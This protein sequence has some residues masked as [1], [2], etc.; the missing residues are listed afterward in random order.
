MR[1][2]QAGRTVP[3]FRR[4][5]LP[6]GPVT[7]NLRSDPQ[8]EEIVGGK[9]VKSLM[10]RFF[11][12]LIGDVPARDVLGHECMSRREARRHAAFIAQRIG[13]ERPNFAKP[14]SG[15]AVRDD[16]GTEFFVA[17]IKSVTGHNAPRS[18]PGPKSDIPG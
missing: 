6:P 7:L 16:R 15:I 18:D 3:R 11:F 2:N 12:D 4:E 9:N 1:P 13:T 5:C 14:G 8:D 10:K 17:P